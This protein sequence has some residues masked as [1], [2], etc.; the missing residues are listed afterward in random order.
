MAGT[1]HG[2][3]FIVKELKIFDLGPS[4][5]AL[6]QHSVVWETLLSFLVYQIFI[7]MTYNEFG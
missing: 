5:L 3:E 6:G 4:G 1:L 2:T 7:L